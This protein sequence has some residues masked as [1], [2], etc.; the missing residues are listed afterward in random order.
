M[1]K[2]KSKTS[3]LRGLETEIKVAEAYIQNPDEYVQSFTVQINGKK[4]HIITYTSDSNGEALRNL[5]RRF[6]TAISYCYEKMPNSYAYKKDVDILQCLQQHF[7]SNSFLKTDIHEFFNSIQYDI[8]LDE[9]LE[10]RVCKRNKGLVSLMLKACFYDGHMPIGFITSPVLSDLYLHDVDK[11]FLDR[12][13]LVYTR[14]ADDFI[15]SGKDNMDQLNAVKPELELDLSEKGLSLNTKKTYY[16]QFHEKGDAIHLLGINLVYNAP[17]INR[18]TISDKYIRETSKDICAFL[19]ENGIMS[20]EEK[21]EKLLSL[22]GKIEFVRH[23]SVSSY[24]K[25][26]KMVRIKYGKEVDLSR[27]HMGGK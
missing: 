7:E 23:F 1:S 13:G 6:A 8:L 11:M 27:I 18:L 5:H 17:E 26:S 2:R 12:E 22:V 24:N 16:R 4:R 19:D 25:L 21:K 9:I 3:L 10:D 15:I 20:D 14:Y